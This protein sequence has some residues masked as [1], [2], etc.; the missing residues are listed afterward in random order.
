M[1]RRQM[2]KGQLLSKYRGELRQ[3]K[4]E[5]DKVQ[6]LFSDISHSLEGSD[7]RFIDY[8]K[9]A[10][11]MAKVQRTRRPIK[12]RVIVLEKV[13][14]ELERPESTVESVLEFERK[15]TAAMAGNILDYYHFRH[16]RNIG[17]ANFDVLKE[18]NDALRRLE[19]ERFEAEYE[20]EAG[21][22]AIDE[23][24]IN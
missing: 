22:K 2:S 16:L 13:I 10:I 8:C 5:F 21:L 11:A 3:R 4:W 20:E 24:E 1:E 6:A 12:R 17:S 7:L 15:E 9:Y 19:I 23:N 14:K 18:T